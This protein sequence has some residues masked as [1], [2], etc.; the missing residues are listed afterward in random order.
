MVK[1]A[2]LKVFNKALVLL[3]EEDCVLRVMSKPKV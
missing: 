3:R 1:I 2:N